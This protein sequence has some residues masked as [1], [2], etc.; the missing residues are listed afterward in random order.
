MHETLL[1]EK[2]LVRYSFYFQVVMRNG[3]GEKKLQCYYGFYDV[4]T[5]ITNILLDGISFILC[6]AYRDK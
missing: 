3:N 5:L 6:N 1:F 2:T 4:V